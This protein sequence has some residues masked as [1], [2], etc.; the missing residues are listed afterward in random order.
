[1]SVSTKGRYGVRFMLDVACHQERAPVSL[2]DVAKRQGISEKY[3][4]QVLAPL[5]PAG[6]VAS[7]RGPRGGYVLARPASDIT[8]RDIVSTLEGEC[9]LVDCTKSPEACERSEACV[10]REMW[11][12]LEGKLAELMER[13]TLETLVDRQRAREQSAVPS[14]SI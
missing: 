10:V 5:K 6:L 8:V 12:E 3:L 2:K 11:T 13:I 7:V 1:M 4:W 14:Y 9:L